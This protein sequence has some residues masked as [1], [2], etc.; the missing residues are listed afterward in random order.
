MRLR[1]DVTKWA[2]AFSMA[3]GLGPVA[4]G[5]TTED[6]TSKT[7][8]CTNP[9][10]LVSGEQ[11]GFELCEGGWIHRSEVVQ[12]KSSIPRAGV[13]CTIGGSCTSDADCAGT[14]NSYC[15]TGVQ[16]NC[17]CFTGCTTDADCGAGSICVCGDPIGYCAPATCTSDADCGSGKLCSSYDA[18]PHCGPTSYACQTSQDQC[19]SD[20]DC[21]TGACTVVNGHRAC[22]QGS[23]AIGRPFL[24]AGDERLA[25]P[26][27]RDD[28]CSEVVLE[29]G[30]APAHL[31]DRLARHWTRVGLMEHA[32]VAAFAR[33]ALQLLALGAPPDLLFDTQRA[34]GDETEH[35]RLC[36]ALASTHA[37]HPVGPGPLRLDGALEGSADLESVLRLVFR[38]GCIGETVAAVE[39]AEAAEHAES[40]ALQRVLRRIADDE[41]RHAALAWRFAG[42]ALEVSNGALAHVVIEELRVAERTAGE[43]FEEE[44][45]AALRFGMV[46]DARRAE[47]RRRV[48][49]EVVAPCAR[50]LTERRGAAPAVAA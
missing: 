30:P 34:M 17:Q 47:I 4:C 2:L 27:R 8:P 39:A 13:T 37:G 29:A 9:T 24:V 46:D 44:D 41:Q 1:T 35:A 48:L 14:P 40:E 49:S 25:E 31:R 38:E 36:F 50:S 18:Q 11:T 3:L 28:W 22:V 42:W 43:S 26:A 16:T 10:P 15:S 19:A 21:P 7:F 45:S 6:G 12:C 33:F 20:A 5:S 23:C 32:S